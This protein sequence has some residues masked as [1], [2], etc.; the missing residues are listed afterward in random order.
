MCKQLSRNEKYLEV[1]MIIERSYNYHE[2]REAMD[3]LT[4]SLVWYYLKIKE[5]TKQSPVTE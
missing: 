1:M 2:K 5:K 4:I 3:D